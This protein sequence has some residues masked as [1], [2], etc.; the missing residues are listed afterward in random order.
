MGALYDILDV[1]IVVVRMPSAAKSRWERR[2]SLRGRARGWV[3]VMLYLIILRRY[4]E[5]PCNSI[6]VSRTN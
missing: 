3:G 4:S 6:E 5:G 2:R 1:D